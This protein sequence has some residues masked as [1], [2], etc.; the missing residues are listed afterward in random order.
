MYVI[1]I[2][3]ILVLVGLL[4]AKIVGTIR[5]PDVTGYIL[6]GL[7]IGPS[8]LGLL[9]PQD[10]TAFSPINDIA[11]GF[12]AYNIGSGMNLQHIKNLGSKILNITFCEASLPWLFV[13]VIML[14][15]GQS[16]AFSFTIGSIASATAPAATILI[17]DQYKAKGDV[18]DT[19]M[20]AVALDDAYCILAFGIA[21]TISLNLVS[22]AAVTAYNMV[23]EPLLTII[24]ALAV[25][26]GM[27]LATSFLIRFCK[28]ESDVKILDIG[29]ILATNFLALRF[30][31]SNLLSL[32]CMGAI[33]GNY[34]PR[35]RA[36][37][38]ALEG[39]FEP[40]AVAFFCFS[41]ASLNLAALKEA[42]ILGVAFFLARAIGKYSGAR[43]GSKISN[44]SEEI[45]KYLGFTLLPQAGVAIGLSA[46]VANV[47]PS[48]MATTIQAI[49]LA[50][51]IVN[52]ILGPV[53]AKMALQKAGEIEPG[54]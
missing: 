5:L 36:N 19:L 35:R 21:S 9:K 34:S 54:L 24:A 37:L 51:V 30:G 38:T 8:V 15:L 53:L 4:G 50:S 52:E 6:A 23:I 48:E 3:A 12:V 26:I 2:L 10:L 32:M 40:V 39:V 28:K 41:G 43:L 47:F 13:T 45:Q 46:V 18:V 42:S 14:L 22:G 44:M 27:G 11:L 33:L 1:K 7:I 49:V 16:F 29:M 17:I 31:L 25:G 20:P